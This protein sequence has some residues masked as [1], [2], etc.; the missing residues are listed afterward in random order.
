MAIN[1][2]CKSIRANS[3]FIGQNKIVS[4]DSGI[5]EN[6]GRLTLK[7]LD[8][9]LDEHAQVFPICTYLYGQ[10]KKWG[11]SPFISS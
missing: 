3:I 1:E 5:H 7:N 9:Y 8:I 11:E 2:K 4:F 10:G 6:A